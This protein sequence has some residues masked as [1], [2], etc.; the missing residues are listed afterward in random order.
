MTQVATSPEDTTGP[1][2][3]KD[4]TRPVSPSVCLLSFA[5]AFFLL[6][7]WWALEVPGSWRG[8]RERVQGMIEVLFCYFLALRPWE[9][10]L[11]SQCFSFLVYGAAVRIDGGIC[12]GLR[13]SELGI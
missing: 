7:L 12:N 9:N 6:K 13:N 5:L 10:C 2:G 8:G 3:S 4:V 1:G 11:S